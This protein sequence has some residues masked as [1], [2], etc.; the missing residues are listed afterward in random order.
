MTIPNERVYHNLATVK[1][2]IDVTEKVSKPVW[3]LFVN[4]ATGLK[5]L[6]FHKA[7]DG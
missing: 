7:K 4:E 5:F 1:A 3:Q 6:T 2:P